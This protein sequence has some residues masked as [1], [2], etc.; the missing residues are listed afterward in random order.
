MLI[1]YTAYIPNIPPKRV[2]VWRGSNKIIIANP[3]ALK[4]T[5]KIYALACLGPNLEEA[6][7]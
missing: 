4:G 6:R 5:R 1:R 7:K 3:I 2:D